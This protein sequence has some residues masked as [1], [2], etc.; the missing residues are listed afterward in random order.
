VKV[1]ALGPRD[2]SQ[3]SRACGVP[4]PIVEYN[5]NTLLPH[6][7]FFS[8]FLCISSCL[9]IHYNTTLYSPIN[10]L[11]AKYPKNTS[12]TMKNGNLLWLNFTSDLRKQPPKAKRST[13]SYTKSV[14]SS[15]VGSIAYYNHLGTSASLTDFRSLSARERV[16]LLLDEDSPFLELCQFAGY[17]QDDMTL[18]GSIV[19][20]IGL[21]W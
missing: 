17:G 21:V 11:P 4:T 7:H 2:S 5:F 14:A 15:L 18:G 20:G 19:G 13:L 6:G 16:E 1:I 9:P 10:H 3:Y 12:E 8:F